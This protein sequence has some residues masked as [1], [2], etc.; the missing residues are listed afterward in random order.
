MKKTIPKSNVFGIDLGTSTCFV[1]KFEPRFNFIGCLG[2][3]DYISSC[4]K[5]KERQITIGQQAQNESGAI[6][7][8]KRLLGKRFDDEE[9]QEE[10]SNHFYPFQMIRGEDDQLIIKAKIKHGK[11]KNITYEDK[12]LHPYEVSADLL[13][14]IKKVICNSCNLNSNEP[15]ECVI[16]VPAYFNFKQRYETLQAAELAGIKVLKLINEPTAAAVAYCNNAV[17]DELD[18]KTILV[19]DIGGGTLDCTVMNIDVQDN[20]PT[21]KVLSTYGNSHLGGVE[22]D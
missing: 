18:N 14:Y 21:Y 9:V 8:V 15:I 11:G 13:K 12:L 5:Y 7:E 3:T 10:I 20:I 4:V 22:V 19:F 16:T 6:G 17:S 2:G 1:F